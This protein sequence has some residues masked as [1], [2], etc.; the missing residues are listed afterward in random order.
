MTIDVEG[1]KR[2]Y[3]IEEVAARY[4]DLKPN[5]RE[6]KGLCPVHT[7]KNPSFYVVPDKGFAWCFA[8]GF[9]AGDIIEFVQKVEDVDFQAAC[10]ILG[11]DDLPDR[12]SARPLIAA[13]DKTADWTPIVPVPAGAPAMDPQTV[14]NPK[15]GKTWPM[16]PTMTDAYR[17]AD[18]NL[19]GYVLRVEYDRGG[20]TVKLTPQVT[21]CRSIEG[22]ER[23]CAV[24]MPSPRPM[25][26]AELLSGRPD[27][28][29]LLVE[30]EKARRAAEALLGGFVCLSW[31]GGANGVRKTDFSP[32]R[33]R[34]VLLMPDA[35]EPGREAMAEIAARAH[36][37]GAEV[38]RL[39]DT[40][41][42]PKGWDIADWTGTAA[43]FG[44]WA[45][46]RISEIRGEVV[47]V[48]IVHEK[49]VKDTSEPGEVTHGGNNPS[50]AEQIRYEDHLAGA[51]PEQPEP[52]H[53]SPPMDILKLARPEPLRREFLP[54]V[55]ADYVFDQAELIGCD[56]AMV[57]LSCIITCA[58]AINDGIK[59]QVKQRD[60]GWTES[61]RLW[62]CVVAGPSSKKSAALKAGLRPL[63]VI[64]ARIT[65][66]SA[67]KFAKYLD[68][69]KDYDKQYKSR[70]K[71]RGYEEVELDV[72]D[73]PKPPPKRRIMVG[74]ATL[75]AMADLSA[76]NPRGLLASY[77]ELASFFGGMD[78]YRSSKGK[79]RSA[80]LEAYE[81]VTRSVDRV[82]KG[83][84]VVE[85]WSYSILGGIQPEVMQGVT[86][87]ANDDGLMQRFMFVIAGPR[88]PGESDRA[89]N[90]ASMD[91]YSQVIED[92]WSFQPTE[93]P[94]KFSLEADPVRK[95]VTQWFEE[96]SDLEAFP[97]MMRTTLAKWVGLYPR[98]ALT[99]HCIEQA[100][101][102]QPVHHPISRTTAARAA[103]FL[104]RFL[105]QHTYAFY[106][107]IMDNDPTM[108]VAKWVAGYILAHQCTE[109]THREMGRFCH[110]YKRMDDREQDRVWRCLMDAGWIGY[111]GGAPPIPGR[112]APRYTV[113][114]RVHTLFA[115]RAEKERLTRKASVESIK[116][117]AQYIR[118][119][120]DEDDD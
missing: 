49:E 44:A 51:E 88:T 5:G 3:T 28:K 99:F 91:R 64:N 83:S 84:M 108:Q 24:G 116:A 17:D 2:R 46:P 9:K 18:G 29:V 112:R 117:K 22:E 89:P 106:T 115:K 86:K 74:D 36:G 62:G 85:N 75:E 93:W 15:R 59:L 82:M 14:W 68:A 78:A 13:P 27:A 65:A 19:H 97:S 111:P 32:L 96:C 31:A 54:A 72:G 76:D 39:M 48:E 38:V 104:R 52:D 102:G 69:K 66:E 100:A 11:A 30:G 79:D 10:H 95:E 6:F 71:K 61:A 120:R 57:A 114:T 47:G 42:Q 90:Q 58:S 33:G 118:A 45:K 98:L 80:W 50:E 105:V 40:S 41:D 43:E 56:P 16:R 103:A 34:N 70:N 107:Q 21:F 25:L 63:K 77:D 35:D 109:I 81:G 12:R 23:W 60:T 26:G 1:L 55:L 8:C 113:D 7:D 94:I 20:E 92:M 4:V 73:S 67:V 110:P 37:A 101:S 53:D 119:M 87:Q